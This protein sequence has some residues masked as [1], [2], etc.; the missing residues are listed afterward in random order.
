MNESI[1][2]LTD[3]IYQEGIEKAQKQAKEIIDEATKKGLSVVN[4]AEAKAKQIIESAE[5]RALELKI[6]TETEMRLSA[7]N[8]MVKLKQQITD[9]VIYRL[10]HDPVLTATQ[11]TAFMHT[12]IGKLMDYWLAHLGQEGRL[13]I[14]LPE[15]EYKQY[16]NYLEERVADLLKAGITVD[17]VGSIRCG[18]QVNAVDQGYKINF[19]DEDFE[20]Y[21]SAFARPRIYKLLFGKES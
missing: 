18:F 21:F 11:D 1:Q 4:Q 5:R 13:Q 17:F 14:L 9:L 12:L 10:T 7:R 2:Q 15:T 6:K 20:H 3:K 16:R 8:A 19:T